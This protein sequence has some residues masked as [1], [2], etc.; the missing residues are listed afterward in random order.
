MHTG[1][2]ISKMKEIKKMIWKE[3]RKKKKEENLRIHMI[4]LHLYIGQIFMLYKCNFSNAFLSH[5]SRTKIQAKVICNFSLP[6]L[7][8]RTKRKHLCP[9]IYILV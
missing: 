6:N 8:G 7:L 3:D 4:L 5:E 1:K 2:C 9:D